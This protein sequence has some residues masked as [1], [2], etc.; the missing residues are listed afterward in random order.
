MLTAEQILDRRR[1]IGS[2][3]IA[4]VCGISSWG[5]P[6]SVWLSKTG[7]A[8]PQEE[9]VLHFDIG[10][11][12]EPVCARWYARQ[13][14]EVLE[15]PRR[16]FVHPEREWQ[17]AMPDRIRESDG[18]P[19]ECKV[20]YQADGWGDE[21]SDEVPQE[22]V[23]QVQWQ[24]DVLGA[25]LAH[26]AAI[27]GRSFRIYTVRR[28]EELIGA[29]REAGERFWHDY[30]L[31]G[32]QPSITAHDRD[33]E[34]LQTRFEK[35]EANRL[36]KAEVVHEEVARGYADAC[37]KLKQAEEEEA[38]FGNLMREL[39]GEAAGVE[40]EWWKCT[41]KAPKASANTDWEA[42]AQ[43]LG[44]TADLIAKHTT[45]KKASRRFLFKRK[46]GA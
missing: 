37:L 18:R 32:I 12:L 43:E 14:G 21:G 1:G 22:Y 11:A 34:Y 4:A 30:V 40:G 3:E 46:A 25:D 42:V 5:S 17:C 41:W 36:L 28:D 27:I 26:I 29:L 38:L 8:T 23:C 35:Y 9:E 39:I 6:L 44:A 33:R 13:T 19:V 45:P 24:L 10:D 31:T 7:Q 2:S 15:N 16:I 20:S